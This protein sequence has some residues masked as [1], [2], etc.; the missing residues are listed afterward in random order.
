LPFAGLLAAAF[1]A[2]DFFAGAFLLAFAGAFLF[3]FAGAFLLALAFAG[4]FFFAVA[5][6]LPPVRD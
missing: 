1:L 4:A 3:A 5:I 6:V 2:V